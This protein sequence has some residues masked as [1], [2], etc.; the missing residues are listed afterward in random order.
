MHFAA[1]SAS[2]R[3]ASAMWTSSC[4]ASTDW[5]SRRGARLL[6]AAESCASSS[7]VSIGA[8][9]V[10]AAAAL[11]AASPPPLP[12]PGRALGGRLMGGDSGGGGGEDGAAARR[13]PRCCWCSFSSAACIVRMSPASTLSSPCVQSLGESATGDVGWMFGFGGG[14][15]GSSWPL[16]G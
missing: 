8:G 16:R 14:A 15:G 6:A 11:A 13:C 1:A 3:I 12:V 7:A 10:L 5:S 2:I 9:S 4:I